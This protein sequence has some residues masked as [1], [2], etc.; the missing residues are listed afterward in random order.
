MITANIGLALQWLTFFLL[1][2]L[3]V[4]TMRVI[5]N[6]KRNYLENAREIIFKNFKL[7]TPRWWSSVPT[8]SENEICFK[9]LD[10]RYD[11]EARFIWITEKSEKNLIELFQEKIHDRRILFDEESSVIHNPSD[12]SEKDLIKSGRFEM[13]RLE[14]TA[15]AD[16]AERLYYDA[17]LIREIASGNYLYAESKSSILNGLV[18]GPYFEEVMLRLEEVKV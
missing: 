16:R 18:E 6:E 7:L 15:T 8:E 3:G 10:T 11:W 12:F 2:G 4:Y 5:K 1:M 13:V 17:F 9:R 14:G